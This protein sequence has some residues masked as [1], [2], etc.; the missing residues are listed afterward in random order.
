MEQ[1]Q[2]ILH[3]AKE[4]ISVHWQPFERIFFLCLKMFVYS[5]STVP[6]RGW[7]T[8]TWQPSPRGWG[9]RLP[10]AGQDKGGGGTNQNSKKKKQHKVKNPTPR[11]RADARERSRILRSANSYN[12]KVKALKYLETT[13]THKGYQSIVCK[14]SQP[15]I[16]HKAKKLIQDAHQV[17]GREY[18]DILKS[19][20]R[21]HEAVGYPIHAVHTLGP[22]AHT[23][24]RPDGLNSV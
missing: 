10:W 24:R 13:H 14:L 5:G 23:H 4:L 21:P 6:E 20:P 11:T 2:E 8:I 15:I 17:H 3:R 18:Q 16:K 9:D 22:S 1:D 12:T 19:M 7:G